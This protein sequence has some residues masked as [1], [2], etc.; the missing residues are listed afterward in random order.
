M[1][2]TSFDQ[3]RQAVLNSFDEYGAFSNV[4]PFEYNNFID[5]MAWIGLLCGAALKYGDK[6]VADKCQLFLH[7][8]LRVG[9]DARAFAPRQVSDNWKRSKIEDL[10]YREK[11]QSFAGP[12][13]LAF[14]IENGAQLE[15][16]FNI[17]LKAKI[18]TLLG[19]LF[20]KA[21]FWPII[22][23]WMKQHVNSILLAYLILEK[24]PPRSLD[25]LAS[26]PFY[27]YIFGEKMTVEYPPD[28]RYTSGKTI[29]RDDIMPISRWKPSIWIWKNWPYGEYVYDGQGTPTYRSESYSPIAYL[30]AYY[31]QETL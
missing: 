8:L 9:K 19:D 11:P 31:L 13:G 27:A 3:A 24:K 29:E 14:A 7:T 16:P 6:E 12:V 21:L 2:N 20:G 26:N 23:E 10:W 17:K 5:G 18:F 28:T 22:G 25:F 1:S 15:N 30:T 4:V